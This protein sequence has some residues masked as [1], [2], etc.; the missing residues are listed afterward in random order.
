[1][2]AR[3]GGVGDAVSGEVSG[4][5]GGVSSTGD[6]PCGCRSSAVVSSLR[7]GTHRQLNDPIKYEGKQLI[8][9]LG[10]FFVARY[11]EQG[12]LIISRLG[13]GHLRAGSVWVA[14]MRGFHAFWGWTGWLELRRRRNVQGLL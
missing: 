1:M 7:R 14:K 3:G 12:A 2:R 5:L 10:L 11:G 4:L 8:V 6:A 9:P 13:F